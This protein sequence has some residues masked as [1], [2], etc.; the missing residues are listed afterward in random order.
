[1]IKSGNDTLRPI[2][3]IDANVFMGAGTDPFHTYHNSVI[4]IPFAVIRSLKKHSRDEGGIGWACRSVSDYIEKLRSS[5][6][7]VALY[8]S[9]GITDKNGNS[10][11]IIKDDKDC[12]PSSLRRTC[13]DL[14]DALVIAAAISLQDSC[15]T[16]HTQDGSAVVTLISNSLPTR[17]LANNAN[18][19]ACPYANSSFQPF[20]GRL[21]VGIEV[22]SE[23]DLLQNRSAAIRGLQCVDD[24]CAQLGV[25]VPAH[26][27]ITT[28]HHDGTPGLIMKYGDGFRPID[29]SVSAGNVRPRQSNQ[30]QTIALNYLMDPNI[31]AVS[32]GG[33]AGSGKSLLAIA[34]GIAQ[35]ESGEYSRILIFRSMHSVAQQDV[36]FLPGDLNDKM[37]PWAQAVWDNVDQIDR[38]NGRIKKPSR[39]QSTNQPDQPR[40]DNGATDTALDAQERHLA[41]IQVQPVTYLRGRTFV[42]TFIIVDDAQSLDRSIILDI[43]TRLGN[44]SKIVFTYDMSQQD[45]PYISIGTG[46]PSIV[47]DLMS[48]DVF[49]HVDFTKSER[50]RLAQLAADLLAKE[51]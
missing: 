8:S 24:R 44:R 45:N 30:D 35:V 33:I 9:E 37:A 42:N 28:Q 26:A 43:I 19:A 10:I 48:E 3:V 7:S 39:R 49:A 36:G 14:N 25:K 18:V 4:A 16:T 6:Q 34:A 50:S 51:A 12:I 22:G 27:V 32:L 47:N 13:D 2:L 38:I 46:M 21:N 23:R 1:M 31:Q 11:R 5:S 15:P 17:L 40:N 29:Y 41:D 20:N